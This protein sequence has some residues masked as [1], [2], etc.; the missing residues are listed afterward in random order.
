ML[1]FHIFVDKGLKKRYISIVNIESVFLIGDSPPNFSITNFRYPY[2]VM[3]ETKKYLTSTPRA[4]I[5]DQSRFHMF[6][7]VGITEFVLYMYLPL[8]LY[9]FVRVITL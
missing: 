2:L 4:M 9:G 7:I 1:I 3:L 8:G 5:N 6:S